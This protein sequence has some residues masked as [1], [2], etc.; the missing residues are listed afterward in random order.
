MRQPFD[1]NF[2]MTQKFGE[3]PQDYVQFGLAGHN[4]IDW[5]LP[6]GTPVL[7]AADGMVEDL[8]YDAGGY[9]YY[10]TLVHN[11]GVRTVYGH[12][13][14]VLMTRGD[15]VSEGQAI[16]KSGSTGN[17]TGPHLHWT[18]KAPGQGGNGYRGAVDP[19]GY[20]A[21]AEDPHPNPPPERGEG[22]QRRKMV[23]LADGLRV[24]GGAGTGYEEVGK[25]AAGTAV[26]VAEVW[27]RR[28]DGGGWMA[29]YYDGDDLMR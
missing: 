27:A 24:R 1:G 7:A 22:A 19:M 11:G 26:E 5:A 9:G 15:N 16:G 12:L 20:L 4:G 28:A 6:M 8:G 29:V 3:N 2:V 21:S 14:R 25:A 13:S 23:V 18:V 17:S 10:I